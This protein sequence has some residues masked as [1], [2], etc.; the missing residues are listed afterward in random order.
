M[1]SQLVLRAGWD[2]G[3]ETVK[4][5]PAAGRGGRAFARKAAAIEKPLDGGRSPLPIE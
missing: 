4:R 1:P 2:I 5:P 3:L